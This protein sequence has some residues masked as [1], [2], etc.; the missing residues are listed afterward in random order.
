MHGE[1]ARPRPPQPP[2]PQPC[3]GRR[4]YSPPWTRAEKGDLRGLEGKKRKYT[5]SGWGG[6][7]GRRDP[8]GRPLPLNSLL[9]PWEISNPSKR[10][11]LW[12]LEGP[13]EV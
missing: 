3:S 5:L 11:E 10:G 12:A 1:L 2:A 6:H 4:S 13:Q 9:G 7:R 8:V